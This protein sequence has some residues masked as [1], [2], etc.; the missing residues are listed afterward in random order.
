MPLTLPDTAV[1]GDAGHIADHNLIKTAL[2]YFEAHPSRVA[3]VVSVTKADLFT[4]SSTSYVD[5]TDLTATITPQD[6]SSLVLVMVHLALWNNTS[7]YT[8]RGA[9]LRGSTIIGGGTP[10]GSR[11]AASFAVSAASGANHAVS[12]VSMTHL[13]SPASASAVVYKV[14][15]AAESGSSATVNRGIAGDTDNVAYPRLA[16]SI[17]LMEVLA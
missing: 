5:V 11:P 2:E 15:V 13:D 14:Q 1:L 8:S 12:P 16:S 6:T 7:T 4:T 10:A 9:I 17:T 3:Q